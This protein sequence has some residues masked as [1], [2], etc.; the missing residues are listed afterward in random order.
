MKNYFIA[1]TYV[2]F[3]LKKVH[4]II[5]GDTWRKNQV[6]FFVSLEIHFSILNLLY[7]FLMDISSSTAL[8]EILFLKLKLLRLP[9][10]HKNL[11]E[12]AVLSHTI[13]NCHLMHSA[14]DILW[15]NI[16]VQSVANRCQIKSSYTFLVISQIY[17]SL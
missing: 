12:S 7:L 9:Q 14:L 5:L 13:I 2:F 1:A 6:F 4:I 8:L 11:Q 15:Y 3:Q 17:F 10:I 16:I